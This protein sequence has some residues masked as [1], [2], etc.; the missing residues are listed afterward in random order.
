MDYAH[1][2]AAGGSSRTDF[3]PFFVERFSAV[4]NYLARLTGE[5]KSAA[6]L[7]PEAFRVVRK[8]M[9]KTS[10]GAD[11][12]VYRAATEL[13][14]E[15]RG[16]LRWR[17]RSFDNGT[18]ESELDADAVQP[19]KRDTVQRALEALPFQKRALLLLRDY[20]GLSYAEVAGAL[21]IPEK[22][23]A[24]RLEEARAEYCQVYA[25]IKF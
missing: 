17:R 21:V 9:S 2:T 4:F 18:T 14:R 12:L 1:V 8:T 25:Y 13:A 22:Q 16:G 24:Q 11:A 3:E 15:R 23:V 10:E 6:T 19:L 5:A 20:I 7:T